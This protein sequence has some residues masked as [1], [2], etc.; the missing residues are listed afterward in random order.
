VRVYVAGASGAI[1]RLLLRRLIAAG[2]QVT[3]MTRSRDRA[4]G[5]RAVGAEPVVCDVFDRD[6]LQAVVT[7]ARP[8]AIIHELTDLPQVLGNMRK[9]GKYYAG[10]NRVRREG[11]ANLVAAARNAG[12]RRFLVQSMASWYAPGGAGLKNE[13]DPLYLKAPE[14]IGGGVRALK[15]MEDIVTSSGLEPVILR[16]GGFYGP[17]TWFAISGAVWK[18]VLEGRYPIVGDG[19]GV[20]SWIHVD[21]AAAATV[22]ALDSAPTGIYNVVDDDPAPTREWLPVYAEAIGARPPRRVPVW[23]ASLLAG[24]GFVQWT[25]TMP[26]A[27]NQKIKSE[28]SWRPFYESWRRGFLEGLG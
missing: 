23:L 9:L 20:A 17:G 16:Y 10:N 15:E 27:S 8:D 2:H 11:T 7:Q 21:D 6:G 19:G 26:G 3:G 4:A 12:A 5:I 22:T 1:G 28:T 13:Q 25:R 14:P 18:Q 24:R